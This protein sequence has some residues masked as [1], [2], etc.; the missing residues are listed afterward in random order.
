MRWIRAIRGA[1][2]WSPKQGLSH[3]LVLAA[4]FVVLSRLIGI[5]ILHYNAP[6][7]E[8]AHQILGITVAF[9]ALALFFLAFVCIALGRLGRWMRI[10][11]LPCAFVLF[12][13]TLVAGIVDFLLIHFIG[14]HFTPTIL[15]NFG[16][17]YLRKPDVLSA[18]AET[19]WVSTGALLFLLLLLLGGALILRRRW[20]DLVTDS[21]EHALGLTGLLSLS[22]VL[23]VFNSEA[24]RWPTTNPPEAYF[25]RSMFNLHEIPPPTHEAHARENLRRLV[26][27]SH[28]W[29]WLGHQY[30]L[31]QGSKEAGEKIARRPDILVIAI[32]SLRASALGFVN[33]QTQDS[34]SPNLDRL[35]REGIAF[36]GFI[37]NG[38]PSDPGFFAIHASAWPHAFKIICSEF[39]ELE[40]D[41]LP[42]RLSELN[43]ATIYA[44]ADEARGQMLWADRWYDRV[45]TYERTAREEGLPHKKLD[46]SDAELFARLQRAIL[47]HDRLQPNKPLFAYLNNQGT[48]PFYTIER[49][50]YATDEQRIEAE[51]FSTQGL[52]DPQERYNRVLSLFDLQF[53]K[54]LNFLKSRKRWKETILVVL[55][56]HANLTT[57]PRT[58]E[59]ALPHDKYVWT[60][61][62]I[63]G[64]QRYLGP[65]P[66]VENFPASQVDIF[67]TVMALVGDNRPRFAMGRDLLTPTPE[68][69]RSAVAVR[70]GGLRMDRG[71]FTLFVDSIDPSRYWVKP[72]FSSDKLNPDSQEKT[73][74]TAKDARHL[75]EGVSY[76]SYLLESGRVWNAASAAKNT[77]KA[78]AAR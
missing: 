36:P 9:H 63:F 28:G 51:A 60:G 24:V 71:D 68:K 31:M 39:K 48:H 50:Y 56:D 52:A 23:V 12:S 21:G 41:S 65:L 42:T 19:P 43:Y 40:I 58:Y 33:G 17:R 67:P 64:P 16:L 54:F 18:L 74:F 35:A 7:S 47:Q 57:E 15:R 78:R 11:L 5:F 8:T 30:P 75:F 61:A 38:F 45:I 66:R 59:I 4:C 2:R 73:P 77:A 44:A 32:E 70:P 69:K 37:A 49:K 25:F 34:P 55:G 6:A 1:G 62:F 29:H 10:I 27:D 72:R 3:P 14:Q 13:L 26:G 76:W 53:G 22:L 20:R 46:F